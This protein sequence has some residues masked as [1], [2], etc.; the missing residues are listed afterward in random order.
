MAEAAEENLAN[1]RK[2]SG[3]GVGSVLMSILTGKPTVTGGDAAAQ[4]SR[5]IDAQDAV[6][7]A[8]ARAGKIYKEDL[9]K[10]DAAAK[11]AANTAEELARKAQ[12]AFLRYQALVRSTSF[13]PD[14]LGGNTSAQRASWLDSQH[15]GT[16]SD[17]ELSAIT[18]PMA[19]S[20][21]DDVK[22]TTTA[23]V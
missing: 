13:S 9:D 22:T 11:K 10:L 1:V 7:S 3:V 21:L 8:Y 16:M 14:S 18:G 4:A 2:E 19:Q 5:L 20:I 23:A 6:T 15:L 17:K 12:E